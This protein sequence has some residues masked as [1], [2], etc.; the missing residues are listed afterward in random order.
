MSFRTP[1]RLLSQFTMRFKIDHLQPNIY[2]GIENFDECHLHLYR[3]YAGQSENKRLRVMLG[4]A[5]GTAQVQPDNVLWLNAFGWYTDQARLDKKKDLGQFFKDFSRKEIEQ[6]YR[7]LARDIVGWRLSNGQLLD[8]RLPKPS[9]A[10]YFVP[11][12]KNPNALETLYFQQD[13][14]K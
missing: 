4:T 8:R 10:L 3:T 2:F 1:L 12:M 11:K 13:T 14:K 6:A 7:D 5:I 9:D